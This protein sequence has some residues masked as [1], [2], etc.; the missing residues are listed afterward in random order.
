[1]FLTML[2]IMATLQIAAGLCLLLAYGAFDPLYCVVISGNR[3]QFIGPPPKKGTTIVL[4]YPY[5]EG[6]RA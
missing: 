4:D 2:I 3:V 6:D 1:M 5:E